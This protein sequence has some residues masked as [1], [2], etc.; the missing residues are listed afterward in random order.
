M[1]KRFIMA[2]LALTLIWGGEE[3]FA[4]GL[5]SGKVTDAQGEPVVGAGVLVKGTTTG[6]T[7]D[8]DG[9]WSL[10]NVKSGAVLEISSI[11]YATTQVA[12]GNARQYNVT[13][14]EDALF[15]F[16]ARTR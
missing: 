10:T 14:K 2:M 11:G 5:V 13:L 7:T 15:L 3:A 6:T 9:N 12:V 16:I 4:Q 8:L 1:L